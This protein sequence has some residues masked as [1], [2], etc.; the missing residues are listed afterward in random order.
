MDLNGWFE[1]LN[2][3]DGMLKTLKMKP[4]IVICGGEPLI[5][6]YL[7]SVLK[8]INKLWGGTPIS[9][10][11]N[12]TKLTP[13]IL[14]MLKEHQVELQVS[15]DGPNAEV[16][17]AVRGK[18][19]FEKALEGARLAKVYGIKTNILGVLS[20]KSS[21]WIPE[22][23]EMAKENSLDSMNFTRFIPQ[24][25]GA[26]LV[27]S[28]A[29]DSLYGTDLRYVLISIVKMSKDYGVKTATDLPLY[30]LID[31]SLGKNGGFG[32]QGLVVDYKGNLKVSSRADYI[33]GNVLAEGLSSLF[34]KHPVMKSLRNREING[35]GDCMY[36]SRCG[37]DRNI[38][39]ATTGSFLEKD[40][41]CWINPEEQVTRGKTA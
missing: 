40:K 15:I 24:G 11:T 13:Q 20:K 25:Q 8:R 16:H 18:G 12:G 28:G 5:S 21:S 2:Q 38:S 17:D 37:G 19:N 33:L 34:L 22:F 4:S 7:Y 9:I 3:Y 1:V 32:F 6:P 27:E 26:A 30:H 23:F 31:S 41:G 39:Y 14:E 35:C 10:L 36:Y 29:D